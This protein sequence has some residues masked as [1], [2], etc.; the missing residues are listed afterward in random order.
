MIKTAFEVMLQSSDLL[1]SITPEGSSRM[2]WQEFHNKLQAFYLFEH[3]D[4]VLA[5]PPGANLN[6]KQMVDKTHSLGPFYS[7]WATEGV[8]HHYAYVLATSGSLPHGL[9]SGDTAHLP[10]ESLVP[11]HTGMGLALAEAL[12]RY[13][14]EAKN[15]AENFV[16]LCHNNSLQEYWPAAVEALGLVVCNLRPD[17]IPPLDLYF[18][19]TNEE[20]LAYFWHGMGR[21]IYFAP[22]NSLP[23]WSAPWQC[24][25]VAM[26]AP[27]ELG[28]RNAVAGCAWAMVLVNLR[29]P[30]IMAAFL[31]RYG[32]HLGTNDAFAN[33]IFSA[34]A[35]WLHCAPND[36]AVRSFC[37]YQPD[38]GKSSVPDLWERQIRRPG[39]QAFLFRNK[40]GHFRLNDLFSY[41]PLLQYAMQI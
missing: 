11:L 25:E 34:L 33:G 30:E 8:G 39:N 41:R 6:L 7:V 12:L 20:M 24:F 3:V 27:H 23:C 14:H 35:I 19:H 32:S 17:L 18:S 37:D 16:Q 38:P 1:K 31:E 21:G 22:A 26:Q 36:S 13:G 28:R 10:V 5:L 15:L 40:N 9:L 2:E 4:S 29:H